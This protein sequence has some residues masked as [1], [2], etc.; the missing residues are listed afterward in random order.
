MKM[1][2]KRENTIHYCASFI[3]T[4]LARPSAP[5]YEI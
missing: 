4:T 1:D 3:P 5:F 2:E